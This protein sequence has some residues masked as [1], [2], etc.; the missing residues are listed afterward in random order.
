MG[1]KRPGQLSQKAN[2]HS[3]RV[4][5]LHALLEADLGSFLG[6]PYNRAG[7]EQLIVGVCTQAEVNRRAGDYAAR[8]RTHF[9]GDGNTDFS[10]SS[11]LAAQ[12]PDML[13]RAIGGAYGFTTDI[14]G[15]FDFVS[16]ATTKELF[17]RWAQWAVLS[18]VFRV[19]GS[20]NAGTHMPWIY[21]EETIRIW[22]EL[23]ALRLRAQPYLQRLW[24]E[25]QDSGMPITR[26]LWL[27]Y[28]RDAQA[29]AQDQQ[30]LLGEDVLVAPVVTAGAVSREVY[31][32]EGCWEHGDT[33]A[34]YSGPGAIEV[35]APLDELPYFFRCGSRPF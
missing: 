11:G 33:G 29:A 31:F 18:P 28:P 13:N 35:A 34:R 17:I 3:A 25:A 9:A 32:P 2:I 4:Q 14:G 24:R 20:T 21:D 8:L 23:S 5:V 15:Y 16:P 19:H 1:R 6:L 12:A 22:R 30:W 7:L 26:P 27:A 10:R